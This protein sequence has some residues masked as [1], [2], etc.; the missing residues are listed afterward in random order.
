M[1]AYICTRPV[2]MQKRLLA[3]AQRL[4]LT[5]LRLARHLAEN[6]PQFENTVLIGLQPRGSFL[7]R[8]LAAL[9]EQQMGSS[10]PLG[11]LDATFH[12]DDFRR[13]AT[14][15]QPNATSIPFVV[16]GR[17]VILIDDVLY[18]GR[19]VR[20]ALD[21]LVAY[22]R[23]DLVELLVL[24]DRNFTREL[25]IEASYVGMHINSTLNERVIA[26]WREQGFDSDNIWLAE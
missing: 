20:A 13:K 11:L 18:T 25:P 17:K 24:I 14:P 10:L 16:E 3:S 19:S 6:H 23:P 8:R 2:N 5:L 26:E 15:A 1:A 9:I 22:G 21:A 7:A 4:D 12:R